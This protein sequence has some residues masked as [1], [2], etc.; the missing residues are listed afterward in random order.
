VTQHGRAPG[1]VHGGA[2]GSGEVQ[3]ARVPVGVGDV[4]REDAMDDQ[5]DRLAMVD[6]LS[7]KAEIEV[8][9]AQRSSQGADGG[10]RGKREERAG[11]ALL[12]LAILFPT[13][14]PIRIRVRGRHTHL[15]L[16]APSHLHALRHLNRN[17]TSALIRL[18]SCAPVPIA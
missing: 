7:D 14:G 13:P 5:V 4:E 11:P 18:A 10:E 16:L 2:V 1:R 12:E 9:V 15:A 8:F 3:K 6:A 17:S